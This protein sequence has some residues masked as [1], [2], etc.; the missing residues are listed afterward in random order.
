MAT[1]QFEYVKSVNIEVC[2]SNFI[3][4][5]RGLAFD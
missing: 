2:M 4:D 3:S 1:W 5:K